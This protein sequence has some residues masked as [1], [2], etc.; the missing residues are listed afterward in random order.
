MKAL[1]CAERGERF[2]QADRLLSFAPLAA[3]ACDRVGGL[4]ANEGGHTMPD[5]FE[6][7][8]DSILHRPVT[9]DPKIPGVIAMLSGRQSNIHEP[10]SRAGVAF[11][12]DS[13]LMSIIPHM[14]GVIPYI[15]ALTLITGLLAVWISVR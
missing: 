8:A 6:P 10:K 12:R 3:Q 5:D 15:K 2:D 11:P 4:S 9:F 14:T 7:A 13:E 1:R